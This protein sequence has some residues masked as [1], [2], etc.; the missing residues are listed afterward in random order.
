MVTLPVTVDLLIDSPDDHDC[1]TV[2]PLLAKENFDQLSRNPRIW[3]L[4]AHFQNLADVTIFLQNNYLLPSKSAPLSIPSLFTESR[5]KKINDL[6]EKGVFHVVLILQ[7]PKNTRIFNS[8]FIDKLKNI[9]MAAAYKKSRLV[10]QAYNDYKKETILIQV[11][12]IQ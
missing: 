8:R 1:E 10:V 5:Q 6:I 12:T 3:R 11:P 4:P 9:G 7:V 2:S